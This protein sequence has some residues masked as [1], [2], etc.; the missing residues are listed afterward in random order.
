MPQSPIMVIPQFSI[1]LLLIIIAICGVVFLFGREALAD[2]SWSVGLI[3]AVIAIFASLM[4]YAAIFFAAWLLS[5]LPIFQTKGTG[6]S[7]ISARPLA[8]TTSTTSSISPTFPIAWEP[9]TAALWSPQP[10]SDQSGEQ[11]GDQNDGTQSR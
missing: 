7:P 4:T 1:R 8:A 11:N 6:V 9:A 3:A 10:P 2:S 5:L